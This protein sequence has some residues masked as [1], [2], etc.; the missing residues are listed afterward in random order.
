MLAL[1]KIIKKKFFCQNFLIE[2]LQTK[3]KL[4]RFRFSAEATV[5]FSP[6]IIL[7]A[8]DRKIIIIHSP[9]TGFMFGDDNSKMVTR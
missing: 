6:S 9:N 4:Y 8:T 3:L 2:E 5:E 1:S 7:Q